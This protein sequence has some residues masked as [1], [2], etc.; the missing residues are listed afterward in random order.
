M[1]RAFGHWVIGC[2]L[3]SLGI[4]VIRIWKDSGSKRCSRWPRAD[5][6]GWRSEMLRDGRGWWVEF[7]LQMIVMRCS[8]RGWM[9]IMDQYFVY[10]MTTSP[11][12]LLILS[13]QKCRQIEESFFGR[14]LR[15]NMW[16]TATVNPCMYRSI[17]NI[18]IQSVQCWW[19]QHQP[20][21]TT[22]P[23]CRCVKTKL[24]CKSSFNGPELQPLDILAEKWQTDKTETRSNG[25]RE[26][27]YFTDSSQSR[28]GARLQ[29]R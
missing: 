27:F 26:R 11:V 29:E 2:Y 22:R 13:K 1:A 23:C 8:V 20:S 7:D 24:C 19:R 16:S 15:W 14:T 9:E 25:N 21:S 10:I 3:M 6:R 12:L 18:F 28:A 4:P 17:E 5:H